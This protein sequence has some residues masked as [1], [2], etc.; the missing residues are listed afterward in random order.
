MLKAYE[1]QHRIEFLQR[2]WKENEKTNELESS[3][4]TLTHAW[5]AATPLFQRGK[6]SGSYLFAMQKTVIRDARHA[7]SNALRWNHKVLTITNRLERGD[8]FEVWAKEGESCQI[9]AS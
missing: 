3:E 7:C 6:F 2:T 4:K 1:R 8:R 5:A 9:T